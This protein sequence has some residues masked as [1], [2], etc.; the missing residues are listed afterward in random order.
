MSSSSLQEWLTNTF[1]AVLL[2]KIL[3][4]VSSFEENY[5]LKAATSFQSVFISL[6]VDTSSEANG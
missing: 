1:S 2:N 6:T 4:N 5:Y 3:K